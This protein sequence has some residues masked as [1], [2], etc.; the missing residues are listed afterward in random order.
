MT[1]I[2]VDVHSLMLAPGADGQGGTESLGPLLAPR[3]VEA[4]SCVTEAG[5]ALVL[6]GEGPVLRLAEESLGDLAHTSRRTLPDDAVGWL[7]TNDPAMGAG[8]G[9]RV[10]LRTI[11][12]GPATGVG[13]ARMT[14][15][16]EA[17]D[18][19]AVAL[20]ILG[21]EAMAGTREGR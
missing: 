9:T 21:E 20:L 12:V 14:W 19:F 16:T 8:T 18:L 13:L 10:G 7:V 2:H 1:T 4:L 17:R 5:H 6:I 3:A 15:D 11:L